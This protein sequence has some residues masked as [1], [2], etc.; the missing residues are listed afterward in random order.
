MALS[1]ETAAALVAAHR[2][3]C[4]CVSPSKSVRGGQRFGYGWGLTTALLLCTATLIVFGT[5]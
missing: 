4:D 3:E 2:A 1:L 5:P